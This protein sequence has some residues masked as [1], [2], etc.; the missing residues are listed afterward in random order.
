M[1]VML[2]KFKLSSPSE[3]T[4]HL[5]HYYQLSS[6]FRHENFRILVLMRSFLVL[7]EGMG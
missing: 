7:K 2:E 1:Y 4:V 6:A 3:T 5:S